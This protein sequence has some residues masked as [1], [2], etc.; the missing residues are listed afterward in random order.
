MYNI[1]HYVNIER[2]IIVQLTRYLLHHC[3]YIKGYIKVLS[4]DS[5]AAVVTQPTNLYE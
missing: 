2:L 1:L 4:V 5:T 3:I